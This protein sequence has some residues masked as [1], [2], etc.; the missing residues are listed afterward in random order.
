VCNLYIFSTHS[1]DQSIL[2]V[3]KGLVALV[4]VVLSRVG[5]LSHLLVTV[6]TGAS[7]VETVLR[8]DKRYGRLATEV[9]WL[10]SVTK[11]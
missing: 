4:T 7:F 11:V 5:I 9:V 8:L 1:E 2:E 10:V 3:G 6:R